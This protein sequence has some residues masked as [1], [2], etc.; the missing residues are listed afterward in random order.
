MKL[1]TRVEQALAGLIE[2]FGE[3]EYSWIPEAIASSAAERALLDELLPR[4]QRMREIPFSSRDKLHCALITQQIV[5]ALL[6][7]L[8]GRVEV[9]IYERGPQRLEWALACMQQIGTEPAVWAE[10][11]HPLDLP[12]C[13]AADALLRQLKVGGRWRLAIDRRQN[14]ALVWFRPLLGEYSVSRGP[15]LVTSPFRF[16]VTIR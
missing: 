15:L 14:H 12:A 7:S 4:V 10:D 9:E 16:L 11:I 3:A 13:K 2:R 5:F 1:D 8:Q 6:L